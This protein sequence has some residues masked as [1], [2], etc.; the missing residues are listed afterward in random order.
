ML[1]YTCEIYTH[2]YIEMGKKE[3]PKFYDYDLQGFFFPFVN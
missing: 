1:L 2:F 3:E